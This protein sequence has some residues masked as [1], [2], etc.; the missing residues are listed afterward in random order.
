MFLPSLSL[1]NHKWIFMPEHDAGFSRFTRGYSSEK[2]RTLRRLWRFGHSRHLGY[3]VCSH[4]QTGERAAIWRCLDPIVEVDVIFILV[5]LIFYRKAISSNEMLICISHKPPDTPKCTPSNEKLIFTRPR[6]NCPRHFFANFILKNW[7]K[8]KQP[9]GK[10]LLNSFHMNGHTQG[11]NPG[12]LT[13]L[14]ST[15]HDWKNDPK[16]ER[17]AEWR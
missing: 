7:L 13:K 15:L 12:T 14:R 10:V 9:S 8:I 16:R 4:I 1:R 2:V 3:L 17:V 5:W 11:C 6:V